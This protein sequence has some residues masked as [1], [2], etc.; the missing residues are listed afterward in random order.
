MNVSNDVYYL[1][2]R[3]YSYKERPHST[4]DNRLEFYGWSQ[5]KKVI[6]A[7]MIQRSKDK[8]KVV[9]KYKE[10]FP[11]AML[12]SWVD[13]ETMIDFIMLPSVTTGNEVPLFMTKQEMSEVEIKL[14]KYFKELPK[15]VE[16]AN[17]EITLLRMYTNLK[18][19]YHDVLNIIGYQPNELKTLYDDS[20]SDEYSESYI[21]DLYS[22][23]VTELGCE[24]CRKIGHDEIPGRDWAIEND[25]S[26]KIIYSVESF[27]KIMKDD[28]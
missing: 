14:R 21:K 28:L 18:D 6:K 15:L 27:V 16:M 5:D 26:Y 25:I 12:E 19:K 4:P 2:F 23:Y 9:K 3:N 11:E 1:V 8:Y 10:M 13:I 17:G 20:M 7:F 22:E 24:D